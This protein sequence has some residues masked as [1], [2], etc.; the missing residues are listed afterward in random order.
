MQFDTHRKTFG[1]FHQIAVTIFAVMFLPMA[2]WNSDSDVHAAD[3]LLQVQTSEPVAGEKSQPRAKTGYPQIVK[4]EPAAGST[5]ID[6]KL[7]EIRVTFDRAMSRGMSWTGGRPDFPP[8]NKSRKARWGDDHT[9]VLPVKLKR[10]SYYRLGVNSKS[11]Q[12]FKSAD[13]IPAPP[14]AIFFTTKGATQAQE[15]KVRIPQ[16]VELSPANGSTDVPLSTKEI[17]VTF[18]MPM[19][20]GMSWTGGGDNFPES[21][22]GRRAVWSK[23]ARTCTLPVSLK[24]NKDYK[25]GLNSL[26]HN[27][28]QS[29]WGVPLTPVVYS[30]QTTSAEQ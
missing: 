7:T 15:N 3:P 20:R 28:F 24:P 18:N 2:L 6:P 11:F 14:T 13:G 5:N 4:I 8:V 22:A 12:N 30:L 19:G 16:I 26:S 23:D 21:P 29:K 9:C 27:N 10:R 17:R 25:I 1:A